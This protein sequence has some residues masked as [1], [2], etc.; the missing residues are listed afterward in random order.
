MERINIMSDSDLHDIFATS[1][2]YNTGDHL[3]GDGDDDVRP[4]RRKYDIDIRL[5]HIAWFLCVRTRGQSK[6]EN[7]FNML[8]TFVRLLL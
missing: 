4:S 7:T 6:L 8:G 2:A 1:Q 3:L 5:F